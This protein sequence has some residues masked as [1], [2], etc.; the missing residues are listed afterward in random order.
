EVVV[1]VAAPVVRVED[2]VVLGEVADEERRILVLGERAGLPAAHRNRVDVEDAALVGAVGDRS[3]VG[4]EGGAGERRRLEELLDAVLLVRAGRLG[5]CGARRNQGRCGDEE[6][7]LHERSIATPRR[8]RPPPRDP[9]TR[10]AL[11]LL[12]RYSDMPR[13]ATIK[14]EHILR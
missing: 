3:F 9:L 12:S 4:G 5:F 2:A 10:S 1:L 6:G 7:S 14:D 11:A 8:R 13:P